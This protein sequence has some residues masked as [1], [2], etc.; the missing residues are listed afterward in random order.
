MAVNIK[1]VLMVL[2]ITAVVMFSAC[3]KDTTVIIPLVKTVNRTVS[4]SSDLLPIFKTSCAI[5]GCHADGGHQPNLT[6]DK[7]YKSLIGDPD[8]IKVS[9]PESSQLYQ[10]LTGQIAP[11]M[12]MG[13]TPNP[14]NIEA[15]VLT[16]IKQGAKNN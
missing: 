8:F 15:L 2:G 9:D 3:T 6:S 4:F 12:P 10:R 16:W 14:S 1:M 11:Q 5:T 13:K 7:A